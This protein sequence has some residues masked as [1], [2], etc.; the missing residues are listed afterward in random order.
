[1]NKI[2][3][4]FL[5]LLLLP[6]LFSQARAGVVIDQVGR[7]VIIPDKPQRVV[8][9]MPSIT[10]IVFALGAGGRL[11][12][13]TRYSNEPPAA[14]KITRVG[15]YVHLDVEKIVSLGPDLCLAI[16]DGNPKHIIDRL[17][18]LSIPVYTIDPRNLDEIVESILMLGEALDAREQAAATAEK[19]HLRL[20][21]VADRVGRTVSRPGVF[22]QIDAAPIISAGSNTFI[23]KL[24][25]RAGGVNLAAGPKTYPRYS[26]EEILAMR[27]EIVIIASMAGGFTPEE[28][29][30]GWRKWPQIPAVKNHR[31]YVVEADL[32]DRPTPRLIN[33]LE[34]LAEIIHPELA[35]AAIWN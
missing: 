28:L 3:A 6:A 11:V 4:K 10:E 25:T 5:I 18:T 1:M 33:G 8:S 24:I 23:D 32:F 15:S 17:E 26:W 21:A 30:A 16:R 31:L 22:F 20:N 2:T 12:G 35:G 27:P 29:K 34:L 14:R 9:F 19:M 13:A 7:R